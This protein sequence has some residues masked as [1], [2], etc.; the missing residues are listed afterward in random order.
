MLT[1]KA[2]FP[3]LEIKT[4]TNYNGSFLIILDN[5]QN[6]IEFLSAICQ[7]EAIKY[8]FELQGIVIEARTMNGTPSIVIRIPAYRV[9]TANN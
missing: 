1:N 2:P 5:K 6:C 7:S 8:I 3:S 4:Q 9:Y